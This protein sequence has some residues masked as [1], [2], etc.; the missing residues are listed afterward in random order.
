METIA[1]HAL[2]GEA[3]WKRVDRSDLRLRLVERSIEAGDLRQRRMEL[4][5]C[6]NGGEV[7]G[8]VQRRER[9]EASEFGNDLGVDQ[10]RALIEQPAMD[11]AMARRDQ[12]MLREAPFQPA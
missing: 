2:V 8:L 9:N 12:L 10:H 1:A 6:G 5:E 11:D 3:A 4:R 7:M